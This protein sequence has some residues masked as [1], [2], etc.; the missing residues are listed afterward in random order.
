ML[1]TDNKFLQSRN[2]LK[3]KGT[4]FNE[5]DKNTAPPETLHTEVE[6]HLINKQGINILSLDFFLKKH[7]KNLKI[8][9]IA[10]G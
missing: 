7:Y 9:F 2:R 1:G 4:E 6:E 5:K 10:N 3:K 8:C